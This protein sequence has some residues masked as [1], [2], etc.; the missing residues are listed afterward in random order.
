[1]DTEDTEVDMVMVTVDIVDIEATAGTGDIA[2]TEDM[3]MADRCF[4][5]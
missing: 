3:A 2:A 4:Q 1:M 5:H